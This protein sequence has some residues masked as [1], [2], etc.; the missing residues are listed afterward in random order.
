MLDFTE[1]AIAKLRECFDELDADGGGSIGLD[2]LEDPLIGLGIANSRE[3][4]DEL[5]KAI[6]KDGEIEFSEFLDIIK[7]KNGS[8]DST[9]KITQFFMDLTSGKIKGTG[10]SSAADLCFTIL[11]AQ[12]RREAM[13]GFFLASGDKTSEEWLRGQKMLTNVKG[14]YEAARI[15]EEQE[16]LRVKELE[17]ESEED[18]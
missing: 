10:G 7:N 8:D 6:D 15:R 3:E 13:L 11:V 2:E 18:I 17:E 1:E 5:I 16:A 4:V 9:S 12:M 14:S